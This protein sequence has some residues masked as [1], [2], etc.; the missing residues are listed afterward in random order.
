MSALNKF[1]FNTLDEL[2]AAIGYGGITLTKVINKV[3]DDVR[4]AAPRSGRRRNAFRITPMPET[5]AA[6]RRAA[7]PA[8]SSRASTTAWSSL[9]AA[10]RRSRATTSSAL[11]RAAT[12][13]PSTV[14]DCVNVR[15]STK[16]QDGDENRWVKAWWDED[17]VTAD[18]AGRFSTGL[19][20]STRSRI[21]VLSD[22]ASAAGAGL[23]DQCA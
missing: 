9:R 18:R 7:R 23:Q 22:V 21:G 4:K 20:I 6:A 17:Q 14:E 19:Q 2:Y 8:W 16:S 5:A 12:A 10:A 11:S 3:K 13:C 1:S 15:N